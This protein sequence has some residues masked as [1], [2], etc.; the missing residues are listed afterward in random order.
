[1]SDKKVE[2]VTTQEQMLDIDEVSA[3][4]LEEQA[5]GLAHRDRDDD[6][7][8]CIGPFTVDCFIY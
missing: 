2:N 6:V 1:M 5:G 8:D 3:E 7:K 4:E